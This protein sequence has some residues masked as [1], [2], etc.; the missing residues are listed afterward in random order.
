MVKLWEVDSA[1]KDA[2]EQVERAAELA[3][4]ASGYVPSREPCPEYKDSGCE[5]D[6][7]W[8]A[9]TQLCDLLHY[10]AGVLKHAV[11]PEIAKAIKAEAEADN[12]ADRGV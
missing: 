8:P 3:L 5:G 1:I 10:V 4:D 7:G 12:D 9:L 6:E 2:I 11:P